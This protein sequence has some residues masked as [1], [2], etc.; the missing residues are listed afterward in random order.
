[1]KRSRLRLGTSIAM[2]ALAA[3]SVTGCSTGPDPSDLAT[4]EVV[5]PSG[6]PS[7]LFEDTEW[8]KAF[9]AEQVA[10]AVAWN[11]MD[12]SDKNLVESLGYQAAKDYAENRLSWRHDFVIT[13]DAKI[14]RENLM[15]GPEPTAVLDVIDDGS[16]GATL[17]VCSES[18]LDQTGRQL[19][20][21]D[22][23]SRG[24]GQHWV[25]GVSGNRLP[26]GAKSK[27]AYDAECEATTI[28]VGNFDPAPVP[29]LDPDA[30]VIGPAAKDK[31]NLD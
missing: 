9:R 10:E 17:V 30:K 29:N 4:P 1:M 14:A 27:D 24:E 11:A 6:E 5:W 12:F 3:L 19:Y 20:V 21:Y 23:R 16:Q 25:N 18:R 8:V 26:S 15:P 2:L 31:Y 7:G 28:P 13:G 22:A